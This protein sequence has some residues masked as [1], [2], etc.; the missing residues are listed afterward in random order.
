MEPIRSGQGNEENSF[1]QFYSVFDQGRALKSIFREILGFAAFPEEIVPYS[2][3]SGDDLRRIASRL[4]LRE[5]ETLA[6]IA[7]GNGSLGLWLARQ[8]GARLVGVDFAEAALALARNRARGLGLE[9]RGRFV[10]GTFA[11]TTLPAESADAI[12]SIDA[13]WL[14][15][16]QRESLR[17]CA[18]ILRPGGRLVFTSW[19]QRI[20][21]A[22]VKDPIADYRPVVEAAG[23]AIES[24]EY[25]DHSEG[26]MNAI[27]ERIR[28]NADALAQEMGEPVKGL[29][30]EAHFVP[31]LVDGINYIAREHG[32]HVMVTARLEN[33]EEDSPSPGAGLP[34]D[35]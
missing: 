19:E 23:F 7:C 33:R 24:Y 34:A 18:R 22:F 25:L 15:P 26:L 12:V 17:E 6:D 30:R 29:I 35:R 14:S 16:R 4:A 31:G 32:P 3:V 10:R 1:D 20:P 5:G 21:M 9:A 8:A 2:F 13:I 27:Y 11:E 28:D